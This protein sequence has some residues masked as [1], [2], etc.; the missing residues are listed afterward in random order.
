MSELRRAAIVYNPVKVDLEAVKAAVARAQE[1][2]GWDETLWFETSVEDPGAGQTREALEQG[3]DMVIAAGGDGTVRVVAEALQDSKASLAL[4]PS[5]TGNLLA[6]NL[7]LTL[8]DV[9]NSLTVAFSGEDRA[10]DI[11]VIDIETSKGR[12]RRS[13]VVMA[14]LGI[15]AKMLAN[16][17]DDLKKRA[18]WLAY[19]DAL[20]KALLDKNQLEFRYSLNGAK[21]RK[22]RAHTIIVGNCGALPA[23]ILL[24]PDAAVDDGEFDIVLLRPEG[25]FGWVQIIFKVVWENGV[26]RRSGVVGTK[27]MGLTKEVSALRYVKGHELVVRLEKPQEIELDGDPFGTTSA[28][29]T[30]IEPGGLTVRVP[31]A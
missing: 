29:R 14:G 6:R 24:L 13:Y 4:L 8:D 5:G 1:A 20:R 12:D 3:V 31:A 10:I 15:D 9:D 16:T 26:L 27:L 22:V 18:G 17:D 2:A 28:F 11:G 19:V 7:N 25:F 30:W 23:N 21:T